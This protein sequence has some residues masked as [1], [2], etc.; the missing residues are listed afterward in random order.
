VAHN[1]ILPI[2][3]KASDSFVVEIPSGT[4]AYKE[5]WRGMMRH[6]PEFPNEHDALV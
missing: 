1:E 4:R 2:V 5:A 3:E 6:A